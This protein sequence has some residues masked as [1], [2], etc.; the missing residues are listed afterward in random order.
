M[1]KKF[2]HVGFGVE[3][4]DAAI[5]EYQALGFEIVRRFEKNE[6][7]SLAAHMSHSNGSGVEMFQFIDKSHPQVEFIKHHIA[8]VTDDIDSDIKMLLDRGCEIVIPKTAGVTVK[9]FAFLRDANG[10]HIELAETSLK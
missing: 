9:N 6:P 1:I 7:K 3:N 4:L 10:Q 8:F 2:W 5:A